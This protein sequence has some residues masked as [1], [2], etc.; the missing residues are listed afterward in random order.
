MCCKIAFDTLC[1]PVT[2]VPSEQIFSKTGDLIT[3]K[4]NRLTRNTSERSLTDFNET[5]LYYKE[6]YKKQLK[7]KFSCHRQC[8]KPL[9]IKVVT[10]MISSEKVFIAKRFITPTANN[11]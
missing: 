7:N 11:E 9:L 4:R 10:N 6:C 2:S 8:Y 3:K 5:L 1:I